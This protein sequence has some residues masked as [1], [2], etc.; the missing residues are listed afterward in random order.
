MS[1]GSGNIREGFAIPMGKA[2][3]TNAFCNINGWS[4]ASYSTDNEKYESFGSISYT[5]YMYAIHV[6]KVFL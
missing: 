3:D 4:K 5:E 2:G 6:Y 1:P